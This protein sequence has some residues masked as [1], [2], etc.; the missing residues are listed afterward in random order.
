[1]SDTMDHRKVR[2][3]GRDPHEIGRAATPLELLFDLTFVIAYGVAANELAHALAEDH[4]RT[5][6]IGFAFAGFAITWAW[7]NF[8]W[9]ASAYDT[10]D[11]IY[12]VTTMVQ[13]IGV[14]I[15]ALG[16]SDMFAGLEKDQV[17]NK[18]MVIG[19][20]VMR[21]PMVAQWLRMARED[22][23]RRPV[24][25]I[26][27][28]TITVSQIGW[29][30]LLIPDLSVAAFFLVAAVP[31]AIELAGPVVA[32]RRYSGTPWHAHHIAERYGLL[33][34]IALGEGMIGT[35]ASLSAIVGPGGPGWSLDV[36]V[37]GVAGVALTFGI[38]WTYFVV[39]C[40]D[41]LHA[42]R[43]RSFGWGYGQVPIIAAVVAV[44]AGLHVAAYYLD[45][46]SKLGT[47]GTLMAVAVPVA[48]YVA[49]LYLMYA[50]LTRTVDPFHMGLLASSAV[51]VV[52]PV[53]MAVG[54][55]SL[56]WCLAVLALVPWVTVVGYEI[57]GHRHNERVLAALKAER[58]QSSG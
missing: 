35:M 56:P 50:V 12:R 37:L 57:V 23:L 34:I 18:F 45:D 22:P 10:D 54:G 8:S 39:P 55:V 13:M 42:H 51:L 38:W 31:T 4:V 3:D 32:E 53:L 46:H 47:T 9:F 14:L 20:V 58:A 49:G 26:Y 44:G 21:I 17:D 29:C 16:L 27:V 24:S 1:M 15:L 5:G 2:M 25:M 6:L 28:G 52:A 11:W 40:G 30:A 43:E 48:V 41:L 33:V 36:A 7:I 19:Y